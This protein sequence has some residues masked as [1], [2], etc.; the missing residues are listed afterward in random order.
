MDILLAVSGGID[1][2]YMLHRASELF[3]GASFAV[4]H[5][6]F[7]LRGEESDADEDFVRKSCNS[8]GLTFLTRRFD[9]LADAASR[10]VSIEMS[11][12][13][14]RYAWFSELCK[15]TAPELEGSGFSR[16]DALATAHNAN[17][18]AETLILNIL[19]GCGS[20]GLRGIPAQRESEG[21]TILR[22]LLETG[23]DEIT[24]W[25]TERGLGWRE[26]RTN[27]ETEY[28]RNKIRNLVFPVF[29]E[30]NPSFIRTIG[31]DIRRFT[32]VDDI[33]EEYFQRAL[34]KILKADGG[35]NTDELLALKHWRY[36]LW[37]II[38]HC[39]FSQRTFKKLTA[40]LELYRTEPRGT[41]TIGGKTFQSPTHIL[42]IRH[43]N[44]YIHE[45]ED[46]STDRSGSER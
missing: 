18:T 42:T 5:C 17:D 10:G 35:F 16:F 34:E 37:R 3:P 44:I 2:M 30:I 38:A 6:N 28:K 26:D 40:L 29:K 13:D 12:R 41:V 43:K 45:K 20:T 24:S 23:R 19:R 33:A 39:N 27:S 25:M 11:A 32:Q 22:P 14:L 46:C 9:T 8:L 7:A 36:V 4:A 1:S 21:V 15:G 31:D